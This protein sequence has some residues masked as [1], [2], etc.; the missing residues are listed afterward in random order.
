MSEGYKFVY[1]G[2][3]WKAVKAEPGY[4]GPTI[5]N[6]WLAY[7]EA[8]LATERKLRPTARNRRRVFANAKEKESAEQL[9]PSFVNYSW[10][11][12]LKRD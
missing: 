9:A 8:Q 11:R 4:P 2:G 6:Y 12:L 5:K 1:E 3:R 7:A 10:R